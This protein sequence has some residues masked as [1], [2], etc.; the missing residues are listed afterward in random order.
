VGKAGCLL[1]R[2][3]FALLVV[4]GLLLAGAAGAVQPSARYAADPKSLGLVFERV[5]FPSVR[6]SVPIN[7]WW[8]PAAEPGPVLVVCPRGRGNMAD[9]LPCVREFARRKIAVL[10]FDPRDFGPGGAGESDSLRDVIFASRWVDDAQGALVYARSRAAG[11]PV[12][13]WGQD[14]GAA[15]ALA[16]AGRDRALADGIVIEGV[17]RTTYDQLNWLGLWQNPEVVRRHLQLVEQ[18]DEPFSAAGRCRVPSLVVLAGKDEV[19]PPQVTEAVANANHIGPAFWALPEA[20]HD[21]LELVPGYFDKVVAW[22]R[23]RTRVIQ[24]MNPH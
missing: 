7:G 16:V 24:I 15:L 6:D 10:A 14:L 23:T 9:L 2:A 11:Q 8:F 13:A 1:K 4:T 12:F 3:R 19:T 5:S 20:K 21:G 17:F 18:R 22:I